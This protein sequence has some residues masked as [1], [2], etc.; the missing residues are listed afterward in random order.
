MV[1]LPNDDKGVWKYNRYQKGWRNRYVD[2]KEDGF[3]R[4]V[5]ESQV[6]SGVECRRDSYK[7][8]TIVSKRRILKETI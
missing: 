1:Y 3:Y 2:D 6:E 5:R 8:T 7:K 4:L